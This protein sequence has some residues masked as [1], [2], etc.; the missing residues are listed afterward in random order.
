MLTPTGRVYAELTVTC[1]DRDH[2]FCIT[3]SG[4]ELHDLRSVNNWVGSVNIWVG[5]VNNWVVSV[6]NWVVSVNNW[7]VSVNNWPWTF[8]NWVGLINNWV[9]SINNWVRSVQSVSGPLLKSFKFN[10]VFISDS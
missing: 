8:N 10:C 1:V 6:N 2:Y 3:G 4:S 7:V 5:S 9:R